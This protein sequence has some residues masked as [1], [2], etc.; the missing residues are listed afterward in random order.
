MEFSL[1]I[2]S[3]LVEV[4]SWLFGGCLLFIN[5]IKFGIRGRWYKLVVLYFFWSEFSIIGKGIFLEVFFVK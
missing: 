1:E 4:V 5:K 2:C 3:F